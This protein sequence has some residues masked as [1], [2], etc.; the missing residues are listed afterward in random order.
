[1]VPVKSKVELGVASGNEELNLV[2][3]CMLRSGCLP[4]CRLTRCIVTRH[5]RRSCLLSIRT[6]GVMSLSLHEEAV[7]GIV[8]YESMK[9]STVNDTE[10]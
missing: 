3:V 6:P 7:S 4:S 1:M 10:R 8:A 2:G 9:T 5:C